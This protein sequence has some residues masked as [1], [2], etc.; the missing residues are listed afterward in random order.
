VSSL[1]VGVLAQH[2]ALFLVNSS[3]HAAPSG[4]VS[5]RLVNLSYKQRSKRINQ[6]HSD[7]M[8]T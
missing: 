1:A 2:N 6:L 3:T 5:A 4:T 7:L 8:L